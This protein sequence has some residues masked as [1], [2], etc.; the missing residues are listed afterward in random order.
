MP[1]FLSHDLGARG[2]LV[3]LRAMDTSLGLTEL[4]TLSL[5]LQKHYLGHL[6][7]TEL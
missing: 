1:Q 5:R 3:D 4:W 6:A 2:Y 7:I